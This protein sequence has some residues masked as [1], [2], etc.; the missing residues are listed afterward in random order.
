MTALAGDWRIRQHES[1]K[2]RERETEMVQND[3]KLFSK[4]NARGQ[5]TYRPVRSRTQRMRCRCP[6]CRRRRIAS[7][8]C[9]SAESAG[10]KR[11]YIAHVAFVFVC[12]C[13]SD[14]WRGKNEL[15][16]IAF[17][18]RCLHCRDFT[19]PLKYDVYTRAT[20]RGL[21]QMD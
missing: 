1:G 12:E 2:Q 15:N 3:C 4:R 14:Q 9:N 7:T 19:F 11:L 13:A 10:Q 17:L 8:Y 16:A 18:L 5:S 6:S 20:K 21:D